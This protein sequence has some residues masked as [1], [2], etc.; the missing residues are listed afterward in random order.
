MVASVGAH[1]FFDSNVWLY[2]LFTAGDPAKQAIAQGLIRQQH[3]IVSTQVINEVCFVLRRRDSWNETQI[4]GLIKSFYLDYTIITHEQSILLDACRLRQRYSVS[5]WDSLIIACA[6]H[7]K[8][9]VLY[10]EDMQDGLV[11]DGVLPIVN[12]FLVP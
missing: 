8:A 2:A 9:N 4:L 7:S 11:I 5:F 3:P 10:S 12:P 1:A 6:L